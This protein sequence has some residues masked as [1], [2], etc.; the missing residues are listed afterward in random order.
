MAANVEDEWIN[1][2]FDVTVSIYFKKLDNWID[3]IIKKLPTFLLGKYLIEWKEQ[4]L[5]LESQVLEK[6]IKSD[7]VQPEQIIAK[8]KPYP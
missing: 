1:G 3:G 8:T 7:N 6:I 2:Q 4:R 5:I